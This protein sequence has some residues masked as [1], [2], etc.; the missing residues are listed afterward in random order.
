MADQSPS[1]MVKQ[2][3]T[4]V[5]MILRNVDQYMLSEKPRNELAGLRQSIADARTYSRDYELSEMREEQID[6]AKKARKFLEQ[7]RQAILKASEFNVFG[8]VDV[9]HLTAQI[10]LIKS[11]LK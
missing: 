1:V 4:Q 3:D 5:T 2:L 11:G 9:A 7:A 6:R 8:P 10:D